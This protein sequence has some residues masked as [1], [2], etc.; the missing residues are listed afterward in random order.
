MANEGFRETL[1]GWGERL[2]FRHG[3]PDDLAEKL[4]RL[5]QMNNDQRAAMSADLRKS[6]IARHNLEH[7]AKTLVGTFEE[8]TQL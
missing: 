1:N 3:D 4:D 7:L 2:L 8:I 6:V 5:L